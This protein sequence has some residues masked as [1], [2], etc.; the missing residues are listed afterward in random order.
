MPRKGERPGKGKYVCLYCGAEV[1]LL[2]HDHEL[3]GCPECNNAL[4]Y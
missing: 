2:D 1:E 3:P 4:F